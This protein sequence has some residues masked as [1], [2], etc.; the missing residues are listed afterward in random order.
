MSRDINSHSHFDSMFFKG[1]VNGHDMFKKF[2]AVTPFTD[3][4]IW[5]ICELMKSFYIARQYSDMLYCG[6]AHYT[7]NPAT[8]TIK[9]ETEYVRINKVVI[10]KI[11]NALY[12][13]L[14]E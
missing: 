1:N 11:M 12:K 8:E 6:G 13:I 14:S 3:E 10:P 2:F 7:S 5:K 4:E 9:N